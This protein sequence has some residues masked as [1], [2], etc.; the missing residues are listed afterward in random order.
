MVALILA[1]NVV[2]DPIIT[3]TNVLCNGVLAI[4]FERVWLFISNSKD[5]EHSPAPTLTI[6]YPYTREEAEAR[7]AKK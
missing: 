3:S 5:N 4:I 2:L 7:S 6:E 1:L